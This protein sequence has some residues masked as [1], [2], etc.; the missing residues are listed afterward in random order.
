MITGLPQGCRRSAAGLPQDQIPELKGCRGA[1]KKSDPNL[2]FFFSSS[3]VWGLC[4]PPYDEE[5]LVVFF[6]AAPRQP[7]KA[8]VFMAHSL[9]WKPSRLVCGAHA[10]N[11][12]ALLERR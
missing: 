2:V 7:R 3:E 8:P 10:A 9:L 4:P 5:G 6:P 11:C 1:A 12:G